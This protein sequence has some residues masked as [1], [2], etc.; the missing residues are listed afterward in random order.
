MVEEFR[1]VTIDE[2]NER[3]TEL[4][5]QVHDTGLPLFI[6]Q[7]DD[8]VARILPPEAS[9]ADIRQSLAVLDDIDRLAEETHGTWDM[10]AVDMVNEQR[11]RLC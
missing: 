1:V 8:M 2:F 6:M 9:L 11:K 7:G 10:N 5:H 4:V 3:H